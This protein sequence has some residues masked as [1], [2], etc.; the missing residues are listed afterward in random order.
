MAIS[1]V[2]FT[3]FSCKKEVSPKLKVTVFDTNNNTVHNALVRVDARGNEPQ[4]ISDEFDQEERSDEHGNAY[5]K[6][7]NT[8]LITVIATAGPR[9]D[10]I[11]ALLETKRTKEKENLYTKKLT[12][13]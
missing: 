7:K 1:L 5:F 2:S 13:R 4:R 6:F 12:I 11:Y 3:F 10:T 9:A 8:V